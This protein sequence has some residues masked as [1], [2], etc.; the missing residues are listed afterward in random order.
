LKS[1]AT[2]GQKV[3]TMIVPMT[4]F[5][6]VVVKARPLQEFTRFRRWMKTQ[7]QAADK[8]QTKPI[9]SSC[10]PT[11]RL[12]LSIPTVSIYYYYSA[13]GWYSFYNPERA[14]ICQYSLSTG[15]RSPI[16][17]PHLSLVQSP[18]PKSFNPS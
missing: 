16:V 7:Y 11:C 12:Q 2:K 14:G 15:R 17:L 3:I 9:N 5:N 8:P 13:E 18:E 10:G 1:N 6:S 4:M